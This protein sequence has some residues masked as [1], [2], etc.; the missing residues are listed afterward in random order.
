[1]DKLADKPDLQ[2]LFNEIEEGSSVLDLG[3]GDGTFLSMLKEEKGCRVQG[4]DISQSEIMKCIAKGVPVIQINLNEGI[5]AFPDKCFDYVVLGQTFQQVKSPEKTLHEMIRVG[6]TAVVSVVNVGYIKNRWQLTLGRMPYSKS[7]PYEW[8]NTPN[9]HLGTHSDFLDMCKKE[10]I[11]IV[12]EKAFGLPLSSVF[13]NLLS[14][15]CLYTL[16]D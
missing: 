10:N 3:C 13:T 15:F 14:E 9:I 8:Y 1:M 5:L 2:Y 11:K 12:D 4:I 16:S 7:L 6:K